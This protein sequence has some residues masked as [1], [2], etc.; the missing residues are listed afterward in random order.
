MAVKDVVFDLVA[1]PIAALGYELIEVTYGKQYG[2][3]T[4]TLFI[5]TD[6]E[7]GISL[8]D[9]EAVSRLVDPILDEADPTGG[10]AYNLN[11]SSPGLDRPIKTQRDFVKKQGTKVEAGFYKPI[12]GVKKM[13][14]I[15]VSWDEDSVTLD[16][17][18]KQKKLNKQDI[19]V[20]KPVIEF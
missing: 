20:L 4:L 16:V 5:D 8:D 15:L 1:Q 10:V 11:V 13:Q 6:K 7:G 2:A 3:M 12:D 14:G 19:A 18:G 9:C 17:K